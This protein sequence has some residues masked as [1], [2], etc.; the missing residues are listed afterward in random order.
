MRRSVRVGLSTISAL[1]LA[2]SPVAANPPSDPGCQGQWLAIGNQEI[3]GPLSPSGNPHA[4]GGPGYSFGN[5]TG[6]WLQDTRAML[7]P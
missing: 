2:A 7:C 1:A 3:G 5:H 6:Q 4:A